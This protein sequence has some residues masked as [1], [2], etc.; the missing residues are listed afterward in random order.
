MMFSCDYDCNRPK[1]TVYMEY[2]ELRVDGR[3][4]DSVE[5]RIALIEDSVSKKYF[6][7]FISLE[8]GRV[9][10]QTLK[11]KN[12]FA[13][14]AANAIDCGPPRV[15]EDLIKEI[16]ILMIDPADTL[17]AVDVT[18]IFAFPFS[19]PSDITFVND[20]LKEQSKYEPRDYFQLTCI[21]PDTLYDQA[22][23]SV[24][25]RLESGTVFNDS[26]ETF[27]FKGW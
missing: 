18:A 19:D 14:S 25:V 23:F 4:F 17:P 2:T 20:Y 9:T 24:E 8:S 5:E 6:R 22:K 27:L 16:K 3:V 11:M 15:Y 7:L 26:T 1:P 12:F 21:E 10:Q 13:F